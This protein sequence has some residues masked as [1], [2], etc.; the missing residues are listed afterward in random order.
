[1]SS[2]LAFPM[3]GGKLS[4]HFGHCE[5]FVIVSIHEG[6]VIKEELKSPPPHTP[7]AYPK[8]LVSEGVDVV[9]AGGIGQSAVNILKKNGVDVLTGVEIRDLKSMINDYIEGKLETSGESCN[10]HDHHDHHEHIHEH[11][12]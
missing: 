8:Y 9:I 2:K 5:Q 11:H 10:H 3:S 1:M 7:G 6:E 12:H 4:G